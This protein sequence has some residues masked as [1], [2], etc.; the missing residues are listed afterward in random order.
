M[1]TKKGKEKVKSKKVKG[2]SEG[3][4]IFLLKVVSAFLLPFTFLLLTFLYLIL[5][6]NGMSAIMSPRFM[7]SSMAA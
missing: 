7:R 6:S 1:D 4:P 3:K 5:N 2:K